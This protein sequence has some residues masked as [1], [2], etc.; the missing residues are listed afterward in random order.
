MDNNFNLQIIKLFNQNNFKELEKKANFYLK[1]NNNFIVKN[2]L[3]AALIKQNKFQQANKVLSELI[4]EKPKYLDPYYNIVI[5]LVAI[6]K[7]DIAAKYLIEANNICETKKDKLRFKNLYGELLLRTKKFNDSKKIFNEILSIDPKN[8]KAILNYSSILIRKKL[9]KETIVFLEKHIKVM[10]NIEGLWINLGIAY[11]EEK[12]IQKGIDC[13][14]SSLEINNKNHFTYYNLGKSF[15]LL[16]DY[17]KAIKYFE[18]SIK[19]DS[20]FPHSHYNLGCTLDKVGKI[21]EAAESFK[22]SLK[23]MSNHESAKLNLSHAQLEL[24]QLKEGWKNYEFRSDIKL[25]RKKILNE[26]QVWKGQKLNNLLVVHREQGIGEEILFGSIFKDLS[27]FHNDTAAILD[28]RLVEIFKRSFPKIQFTDHNTKVKNYEKAKHISI[29]SLGMFFRNSLKNFNNKHW[30][31]PSKKLAEEYKK[32]IKN[33]GKIKVGIGWKSIGTNNEKI[34][35]RRNISL[36]QL[37]DIFPENKYELINLQYGEVNEELIS[38]KKEQNKKIILFNDIDYKNDL[39]DLAAIIYNC[40]LVVSIGSFTASFAGSLG[41]PTWA[42]ISS[43]T[44]PSW[45]WTSAKK[46]QSLWFPSIK[47]FKQS[48]N[49]NWLKVLKKVKAE[50]S[51]KYN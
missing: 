5:S 30:L 39:E 10:N 21:S 20:K 27:K 46:N 45:I 36:L 41:I 33:N 18:K 13:F 9:F 51:Q 38:I 23:I 50:L 14:N 48:E 16:E 37:T 17:R 34:D 25:F 29:G 24:G 12:E 26:S 35:E 11:S 8:S 2:M 7:N 3:G 40:D 15:E 32:K 47:F 19:Q 28:K 4:N 43:H 31:I 44:K 1:T 6:G 22:K 49:E 42:L